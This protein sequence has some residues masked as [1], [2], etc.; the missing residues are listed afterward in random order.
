M[1]CKYCHNIVEDGSLYCRFC[2]SQLFKSQKKEISIPKPRLLADG[3]Y[4]ARIMVNGER[5]TIKGANLEEYETAARATKLMLLEIQK[6]PPRITLGGA[7]DKYI[8]SNTNVLSPSTI[9]AYCIMRKTRFVFFVD[10]RIDEIDYQDMINRELSECSAKT[11]RN[12]WALANASLK[13][14]DFSVPNVNLPP[15]PVKDL[16]F[17]APDQIPVFLKAIRGEPG[18]CASLLA[19]H[20][21]RMSELLALSSFDVDDEIRVNKSLVRD[22]YNNYVLKDTTKTVASS[23]T[24]PI[25]IPRLREL[26]PD[27]ECSRIV[28]TTP[29]GIER[30]IARACSAA[31]LPIIGAHGLRRSFASLGYH[32]RWSERSV[33]AYGGWSNMQTVH[34]V[35]IKLSQKDLNNDIE[36]MRDFYG[37]TTE[38]S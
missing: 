6:A 24:I 13:A 30:Q 25:L 36:S 11:L 21:L 18:E 37:F 20:S 9:R 32:L 7:I 35:Y 2:G 3:S 17:L 4:S 15:V 8:S 23:R 29:V 31:S 27:M 34:K 12:A 33:M 22:Q 5:T 19:L 38:D 26:L 1:K 10:K 16:A 28:Q 14:V